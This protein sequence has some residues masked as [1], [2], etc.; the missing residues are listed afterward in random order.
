MITEQTPI[1]RLLGWARKKGLRDADL[2]RLL[3]IS[4]QTLWN[5]KRRGIPKDAVLDIA[6]KIGVP[7]ERLW[8]GRDPE[9]DEDVLHESFRMLRAFQARRNMALSGQQEVEAIKAIY[10]RL[11]EQK[12]ISDEAIMESLRRLR[13]RDDHDEGQQA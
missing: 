7:A 1:D 5:W 4:P 10:K 2:A 9:F 6:P 13:R 12:A 8:Y 3:E 11:M